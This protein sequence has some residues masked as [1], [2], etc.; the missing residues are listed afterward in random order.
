MS[1]KQIMINILEKM[2]DD[3]SM[4][5]ILETLNLI[6]ELKNRIENFA[7]NE[8]VTQEILKQEIEKW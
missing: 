6:H 7:E 1:E 3:I 5:D 2:P 4:N 8:T